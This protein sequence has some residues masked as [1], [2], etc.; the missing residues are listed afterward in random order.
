MSKKIFN[1]LKIILLFTFSQLSVFVPAKPFGASS[2]ATLLCQ[3]TENTTELLLSRVPAC[4]KLQN[5]QFMLMDLLPCVYYL[6]QEV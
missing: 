1:L 4:A 6:S 2:H 3:H 5:L